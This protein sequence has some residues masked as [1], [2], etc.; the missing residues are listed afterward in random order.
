M[1]CLTQNNQEPV[2][3]LLSFCRPRRYTGTVTVSTA[4]H[5]TKMIF[6]GNSP[7]VE[8]FRARL[9][10]QVDDGMGSIVL[11]NGDSGDQGVIK[12][13]TIKDLL[14][15][16]KKDMD[17]NFLPLELNRFLGRKGLFHILLKN[18]V[19]SPSWIGPRTFGVRS[20]VTDPKILSKY[21]HLVVIEDEEA[22]KESEG[23]WA[24]LEDLSQKVHEV[25][26]SNNPSSSQ[27][28]NSKQ[29]RISDLDENEA[30]KRELFDE[31]STSASKKM[32]K[33][34]ARD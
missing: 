33:E 20:L 32:K 10:P 2:I 5:V 1:D 13:T 23:L 34:T 25:I 18:D 12:T 26:V 30:V 19:G 29:K 17:P 31:I 21:E 11:S 16:M 4:F 27:S 9:P 28:V 22:D 8:D 7:E 6:D 15:N 24:S 14:D 3:M